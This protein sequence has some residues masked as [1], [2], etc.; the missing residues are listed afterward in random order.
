MVVGAED[1]DQAPEAP[2]ELVVVIAD[3]TSEIG[4]RAIRLLERTIHV[5]AERRRAEQ[6]LLTI[7]P[8]VLV[9]TFR[10]RQPAFEDQTL[11]IKQ[12]NRFGDAVV[13]AGSQRSLREAVQ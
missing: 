13:I 6:S 11:F 3:V 9:V 8:L 2:L 7:L 12:R 10:P 4:V 1:V 5:V